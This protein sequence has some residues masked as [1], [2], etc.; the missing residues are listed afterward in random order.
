MVLASSSPRRVELL[1]NM[2]L[3]F[4]VKP[5][6]IDE[7]LPAGLDPISGVRLLAAKKAVDVAVARPRAIVI[8]ADTVVV[9]DGQ[10][11][12]KPASV[13]EARRMLRLLSGKRHEVISGLAV[14][15]P[16]EC[17][18]ENLYVDDISV[19]P[20]VDAGSE[21]ASSQI[22]EA[23]EV[24]SV[25]FR[26]LSERDIAAYIASGEPFDKAGAYGVQGRA[27]VFVSRIE[28]CYFNVVGLPVPRLARLLGACGILLP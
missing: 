13:E 28:G 10:V 22:L 27:G 17:D 5:A 26:E 18:I 11:L 15:C 4:Q 6:G 9:C 16:H 24:T 19:E 1:R 23:H 12:G 21:G 8:G 20:L 7:T 14:V 2:G 25:Y 3:S